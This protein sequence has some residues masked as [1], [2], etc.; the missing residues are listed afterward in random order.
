MITD[1]FT[2]TKKQIRCLGATVR[3]CTVLCES[4]TQNSFVARLRDWKEQV[5]STILVTEQW[6]HLADWKLSQWLEPVHLGRVKSG[7]P[8]LEEPLLRSGCTG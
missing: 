6:A 5:E 4:F 7:Q 2:G 1:S 8:E 3:T